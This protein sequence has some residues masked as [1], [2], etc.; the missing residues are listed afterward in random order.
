MRDCE[1]CNYRKICEDNKE[2]LRESD[3]VEIL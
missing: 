2:S 1:D 3:G